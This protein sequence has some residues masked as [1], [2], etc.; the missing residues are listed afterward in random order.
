MRSIRRSQ[1]YDNKTP[2][3]SVFKSPD[4]TPALHLSIQFSLTL[5]VLLLLKKL[6]SPESNVTRLFSARFPNNESGDN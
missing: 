1:R 4:S 6:I 2:R 5:Q 3:E